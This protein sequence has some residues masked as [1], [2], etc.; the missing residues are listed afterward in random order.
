MKI[1]ASQRDMRVVN[2][3]LKPLQQAMQSIED[4]LKKYKKKI[5]NSNTENNN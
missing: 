1:N 5:K 2:Y 3:V 4:T